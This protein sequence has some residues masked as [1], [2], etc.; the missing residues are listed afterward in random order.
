MNQIWLALAL[1]VVLL[2][3]LHFAAPS[4]V[5]RAYL[6]AARFGAGM[7]S[8]EIEINDQAYHYLDGG[9]GPVVVLVHGFGADA[10]NWL[11]LSRALHHSYRT[12]A[13]DLPGF[14]DSPAPADG[15]YDVTSQAGRLADFIGT[16]TSEKVHLVGNSMGGQIVALLAA[17]RPDLVLSVALLDPLGI[18]G[19]AGVVKSPTMLRLAE[20]ENILLPKDA[21][22]FDEMMTL[23]FHSEP[24]MPGVLRRYYRERWLRALDR[25]TE[26]FTD[27][28]TR[29]V[30]LRPLLPEI[31]APTFVLWGAEDQILPASGA[32]V[33]EA[34]LRQSEIVVIP[35]C[36]HLPMLEKPR[37]TAAHYLRFLNKLPA[38]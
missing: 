6:G 3:T 4:V 31:T 29:Y 34:G 5:A 15:N 12:V 9:S 17:R 16:L 19:E 35:E 18:E 36:G 24:W 20:G 7:A 23:M 13:L 2:T 26:V 28:S 14:G 37:V 30:P 8:R 10:D 1:L 33:F 32:A 25:L 38:G 22:A 21:Q 27:I 11:L